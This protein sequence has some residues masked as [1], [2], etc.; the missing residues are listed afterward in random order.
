MK[1]IVETAT[2]KFATTSK[3]KNANSCDCVIRSISLAMGKDWKE[4]FDGLCTIAREMYRIPNEKLVYEKYLEQNGWKKMSQPRYDDNTKYLAGH[5]CKKVNGNV[6]ARVGGHHLS[7][8]IDHKIHDIWDC[9]E[10]CVGNYWI[11]Q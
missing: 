7:C 2:Y 4:V 10:K 9:S 5:F 8:I 3:Y 1:K 11:K 6:I